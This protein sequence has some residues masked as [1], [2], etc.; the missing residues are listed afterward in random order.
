ML[1]NLFSFTSVAAYLLTTLITWRNCTQLQAHRCSNWKTLSIGSVAIVLHVLLLAEQL[2]DP[3]GLNLGISYAF[4]LLSW[5]V[6]MQILIASL[7]RP[8]QNL[9]LIMWPV[10]IVAIVLAYLFPG[11]LVL[12]QTHTYY[13]QAHVLLS[14]IAYSLLTM[15]ML[16]AIVV[17]IQNQ[18]L[19]NHHPGGIIRLLPPLAAMESLLFQLLSFG[20]VFLS[21]ALLSGFLFLDDLFAQHLV[22]KTVLSIA[23][24]LII[25]SLLFGRWR[26]GWRG[27]TA[28][29][30]TF[31]GFSFLMLA[32]FGS[33]MV[34][35]VILK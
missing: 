25:G 15:G 35:E 10:S 13:L 32:Y 11:Q 28:I 22:H 30:W 1:V 18:S 9:G 17:S 12:E 14:I 23:G 27:K 2:Y 8:V 4:S 34:L 6:S 33:K 24:W 16:Q 29:R 5:L 31:S 19:H 26:Y 20:F 7:Y 3:R 21:M